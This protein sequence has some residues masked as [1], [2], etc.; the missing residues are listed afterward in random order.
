VDS[1]YNNVSLFAGL[2]LDANTTYWITLAPE[3]V[4][5]VSWAADSNQP[6]PIADTGV[7]LAGNGFCTDDIGNCNFDY[8]PASSFVPN[9]NPIFSVT[10][11]SADVTPEPAS[12]MLIGSGLGLFGLLRFR[13]ARR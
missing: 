7:S 10:A 1:G 11:V 3:A 9:V 6:T 12:M 5:Q 8:A 2:T 13:K 4:N